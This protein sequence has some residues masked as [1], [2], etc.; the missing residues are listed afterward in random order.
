MTSLLVIKWPCGLVTTKLSARNVSSA[1]ASSVRE[2]VTS[3]ALAERSAAS[4]AVSG[5]AGQAKP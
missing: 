4:S 1:G 5:E 3:A 2:A